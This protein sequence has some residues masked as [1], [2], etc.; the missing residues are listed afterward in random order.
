MWSAAHC[1]FARPRR[2]LDP[3]SWGYAVCH[4]K[5]AGLCEDRAMAFW[6]AANE[7]AGSSAIAAVSLSANGSSVIRSV[8]WAQLVA[9]AEVLAAALC[10]RPHILRLGD[11]VAI[12]GLN[13]ERYLKVSWAGKAESAGKQSKF[14][15]PF[16]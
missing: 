4:P 13:S 9:D 14:D 16:V 2:D 8:T 1:E 15:A 5:P 12:L 6:Q 11:R 7:Q 3:T 10:R